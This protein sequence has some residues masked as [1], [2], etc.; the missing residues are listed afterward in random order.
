MPASAFIWRV[1]SYNGTSV[2]PLLP[3]TSGISSG[4]FTIPTTGDPS[5][6]VFYRI[7]LSVTD[8]Q[9]LTQTTS[10]DI[11]PR[12][13]TLTVNTDPAGIAVS[14]DGR[15]SATPRSFASVVGMSRVIEAPTSQILGGTIYQFT[16]WSDGDTSSQRVVATPAADTGFLALYQ[17]VGIVPPVRVVGVQA[18]LRGGSIRRLI[19]TFSDTLD[20][21]AARNLAAYWLVLPGRDRRFGTRDDRR[22]RIRAA[23]YNA[24]AHTVTLTP[25][26]LVSRRMILQL[27]V[28]GASSGAAVKDVWGRPIDGDH[29]GQPGGN[30]VVP[31]EPTG[32]AK[33]R[34]HP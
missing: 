12:T 24:A 26:V 13:A 10:R 23:S 32:A 29:D 30:Y 2:H 9:G 27:V 28:S 1:D 11:N 34:P 21:A 14:V 18:K 5:T 17:V 19:V 15:P 8:S 16:K 3:P 7:S 25:K 4:S 31:F 22:I 20:Q 33:S 6:D